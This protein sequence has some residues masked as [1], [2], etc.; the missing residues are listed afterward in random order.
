MARSLQEIVQSVSDVIMFPADLG[1]RNV[2]V[3]SIGYDGDTPLHVLAC[4]NDLEGV[5][6]LICAGADVNAQGEMDETP[7][8][9]AITQQNIPM[10][11]VM[12]KA[13]ARDDLRCEFGDT[14]QERAVAHGEA[15]ESLFGIKND[16]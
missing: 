1:E 16:I 2:S 3:D 15:F 8:H 9:I 11:Q 4:R 5:E 12:L 6:I 7:L 13:G 10:I 14:Q